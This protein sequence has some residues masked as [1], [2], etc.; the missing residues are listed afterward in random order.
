[1]KRRKGPPS[2]DT[3]QEALYLKSLSD[4]QVNVAIKL[5]DGEIVSGW[6]EYFDDMMLRLT[7]DGRPNLFIYKSQIRTITENVSGARRQSRE[8]VED[9]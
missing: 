5:R 8:G 1:M 4:R 6:I 3:G 2:N 9:R 7:R